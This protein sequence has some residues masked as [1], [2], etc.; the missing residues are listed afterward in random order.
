[1]L[2]KV[3]DVA[4]ARWRVLMFDAPPLFCPW[5]IFRVVV[6]AS[7]GRSVLLGVPV[8]GFEQW[9]LDA[10]AA[11]AQVLLVEEVGRA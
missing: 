9:R 6:R 7:D 2:V 1:M 10:E 4:F 11:G 3:L 8:H 5:P